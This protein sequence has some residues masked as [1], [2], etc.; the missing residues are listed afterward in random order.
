M[1]DRQNLTLDR[2]AAEGRLCSILKARNN[3]GNMIGK[4][5]K[6]GRR[7]A[8]IERL[9][10]FYPA[11]NCVFDLGSDD[12]SD[13]SDDENDDP[14]RVPMVLPKLVLLIDNKLF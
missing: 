9:Q 1:K 13:E 12:S 14:P 10:A 7:T 2:L 11:K 8:L 3:I 5:P 6:C 4:L